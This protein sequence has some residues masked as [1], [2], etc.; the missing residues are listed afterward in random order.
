MK[1]IKPNFYMVLFNTMLSHKKNMNTRSALLFS[2]TICFF[3]MTPF[4]VS[5]FQVSL[6]HNAESYLVLD[7]NSD[8]VLISREPNTVRPIAS[9]TK[10]MTAVIALEYIPS[11]AL[12]T[13][14]PTAFA[15]LGQWAGLA[16]GDQFYRDD[17]LRPLLLSSDNDIAVA[18]TEYP[19]PQSFISL[20]NDKAREI[21]MNSTRFVE[22]SGLS[23]QNVST[24][25]DYSRLLRYVH[26]YHPLLL[27]ISREIT[28]K[29]QNVQGKHYTFI[30]NSGLKNMSERIGGKSGF[31][32]ASGRTMGT[33]FEIDSNGRLYTLSIVTLKSHKNEEGEDTRA[34]LHAARNEIRNR[35][36]LYELKKIYEALVQDMLNRS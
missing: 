31:I 18:F 9:L 28:Y 11:S 24:A 3:S 1:K 17:A 29:A 34:L 33:I 26:E 35:E 21:G 8:D 23:A 5:A 30:N 16:L 12:I 20:M 2:L 4:S 6:P 32:T 36:R 19:L 27:D 15:T 13:I 14:S 10:L 22:G 7:M 25:E